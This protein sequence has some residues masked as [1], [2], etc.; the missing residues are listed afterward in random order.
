MA[1]L[2]ESTW[3]FRLRT[4]IASGQSSRPGWLLHREAG[5]YSAHFDG[6]PYRPTHFTGGLI[7]TPDEATWHQ[8]RAAL[9]ER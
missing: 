7:C 4:S 1:T 2:E 9:L 6:T 8:A 5:G 3:N